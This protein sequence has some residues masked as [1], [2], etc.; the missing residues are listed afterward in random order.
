MGWSSSLHNQNQ[1]CVSPTC[2]FQWPVSRVHGKP[3][4]H[5]LSLWPVC[6]VGWGSSE[7]E[8]EPGPGLCLGLAARQAIEAEQREAHRQALPASL[9]WARGA[10]A[11][12]LP[13]VSGWWALFCSSVRLLPS[14]V[15]FCA[16]HRARQNPWLQRRALR[17]GPWLV[18]PPSTLRRINTINGARPALFFIFP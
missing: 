14:P 16:E 6:H 5:S 10:A 2:N 1:Q 9:G 15:P 7:K 4:E 17:T 3:R 8:A 18:P 11:G 12:Q 13:A